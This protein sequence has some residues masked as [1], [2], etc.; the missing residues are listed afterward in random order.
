[1]ERRN[2]YDK[3][4]EVF[5]SGKNVL[6]IGGKKT[7]FEIKRMIQ[8]DVLVL[9]GKDWE[10]NMKTEQ[11]TNLYEEMMKYEQEKQRALHHMKQ[12]MF[13]AKKKEYD[14]FR[15]VYMQADK[16][17]KR[18]ESI[19]QEQK[20]V[21]EQLLQDIFDEKRKVYVKKGNIKKLTTLVQEYNITRQNHKLYNLHHV[22]SP[23]YY[24]E[25]GKVPKISF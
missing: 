10:I 17:M 15:N 14:S 6:K 23:F 20:K 8:D 11:T 5:Y 7:R 2:K 13:D 4:L 19:F 1:M 22:V 9:K 24:M 25:K 18:I 16:E 3:W 21:E 12:A